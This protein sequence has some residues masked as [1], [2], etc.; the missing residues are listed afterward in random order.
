[1]LKPHPVPTDLPKGSVTGRVQL[2]VWGCL[3]FNLS[4]EWSLWRSGE[5]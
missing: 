1:M 5:E 3:G 4:L 2:K